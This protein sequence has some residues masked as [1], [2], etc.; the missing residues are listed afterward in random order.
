MPFLGSS[1]LSQR[2]VV[3]Y[4]FPPRLLARVLANLYI[5]RVSYRDCSKSSYRIRVIAVETVIN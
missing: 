3:L 5:G 2:F 1:T 4:L